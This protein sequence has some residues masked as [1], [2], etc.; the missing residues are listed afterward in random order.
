MTFFLNQIPYRRI[1]HQLCMLVIGLS[2][3]TS[4]TAFGSSSGSHLSELESNLEPNPV[5]FSEK[6]S[7][8]VPLSLDADILQDYQQFLRGRTVTEIQT[9]SGKGAR[10]DVIEVILAMQALA[11]G[12]Y[13]K[14][15]EFIPEHSYRRI[16]FKVGRGETAM[17][18]PLVWLEDAS[19]GANFIT[20]SVI[21]EGE[22]VV[23]LYTRVE[24]RKALQVKN[25]RDLA[26]LTAVSTRQWRS[27]WRT[28]QNMGFRYVYD[29]LLWSRMVKMV[30][31][32]RVDMTLAPFQPNTS[33]T[34]NSEGLKLIPVPNIKVALSGSRHWVTSRKHVEGRALFVALDKGIKVLRRKGQIHRAYT[35]SGFFD[36]RVKEWKVINAQDY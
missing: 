7:K 29:T 4:T 30:W 36:P 19:Y 20:E 12:G 34:L 31:A 23:G 17:S 8:P 28:L 18:A 6:A 11:L 25:S 27:D 13:K 24:N 1:S 2:I 26:Q 10:R 9:Y 22:F 21:R 14:T 33:M 5:Q 15:I 16:L 32:G 3:A 35:E